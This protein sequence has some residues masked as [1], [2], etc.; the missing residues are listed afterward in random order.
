MLISRVTA[1]VVSTAAAGYVAARCAR[2]S[3]S[4]AWWLG[5]LLLVISGPIHL[6]DV[7]VDYPT[8]YHV[9]YLLSLMPLAGLGGDWPAADGMRPAEVL[10]GSLATRRR[11]RAVVRDTT[12]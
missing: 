4:A 5:A 6:I 1:G 2:D 11:C 8:W 12:S 7:W 3:R 9:A 10:T